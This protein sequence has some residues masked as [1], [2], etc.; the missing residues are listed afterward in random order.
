VV[1]DENGIAVVPAA[2][3]V[4][5]LEGT[6]AQIEKEKVIREK[7]SSGATVAEL[8]TEFGHL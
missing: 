7:I 4:E 8:L 2:D 1:A 6:R 3:A 5:V